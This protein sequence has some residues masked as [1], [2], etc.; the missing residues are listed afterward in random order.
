MH[1]FRIEKKGKKSIGP[2][3]A[4]KL[5]HHPPRS[6]GSPFRPRRNFVVG[7]CTTLLGL[8]LLAIL[9]GPWALGSEATRTCS[10]RA[11]GQIISSTRPL[12]VLGPPLVRNIHFHF[13]STPDGG[14]A[15][16]RIPGHLRRG[17]G[18][19]R[20][21]RAPPARARARSL[22]ALLRR[23]GSATGCGCGGGTVLEGAAAVCRVGGFHDHGGGGGGS[24]C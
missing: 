23:S 3:T 10:A 8:P 14:G 17:G 4:G 15:L 1:I 20:C 5:R 12:R 13:H 21:G 11:R 9:A 22:A 18:G 24:R 6:V 2:A 19:S 7:Q 16:L